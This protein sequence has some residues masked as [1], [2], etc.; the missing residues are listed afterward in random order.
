MPSRGGPARQL[1]THAG[2]DQYPTWSP[3][4][5]E[6]A[7]QSFGMKGTF[8][9][10]VKGGDLRP[11]P[12]AGGAV[13]EWSPDGK[14]LVFQ[15]EGRIYRFAKDGG[16][17]LLLPATGAH[18]TAVRPSPD[19]RA[20][21]Y[22]VVTGPRQNHDIWKLSLGDGTVSRF[23]K[24]EGRRGDLNDCFT[25]DDRFLY[26]LWREDEGDIWVMDVAQDTRR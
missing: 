15:R 2:Q 8:V 21:Y 19:G 18:F 1:S 14:T 16:E 17:P 23:T 11:L 5:R 7:F 25:S 9:V 24:L 22:S 13:V 26:F 20:I 12:A 10:D 4:G 3:D 6:I